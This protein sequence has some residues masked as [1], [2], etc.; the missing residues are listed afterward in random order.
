MPPAPLVAEKVVAA[1]LY[2]PCFAD[3]GGGE[4]E[5]VAGQA[6]AYEG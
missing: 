5:A 4:E 6:A 1:V 3:P 2:R